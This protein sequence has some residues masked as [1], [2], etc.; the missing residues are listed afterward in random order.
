M[1][2]R[3]STLRP[4][5]VQR[6]NKAI[7]RQL[8]TFSKSIWGTLA[9]RSTLILTLRSQNP[10]SKI[11]ITKRYLQSS[12]IKKSGQTT[13]RKLLLTSSLSSPETA[14]FSNP[15]S[16]K[17]LS[18]SVPK[19]KDAVL[20]ISTSQQSD[21]QPSTLWSIMDSLPKKRR[22]KRKDPW[23]RSKSWKWAY[24]KKTSNKTRVSTVILK[25]WSQTF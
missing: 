4:L 17:A 13:S 25:Q 22:A 16:K 14:H 6:Q 7:S 2:T 5:R 11:L 24:L 19:C 20:M 18:A 3:P 9:K 1:C 10:T 21:N 23:Q 15:T 8:W 12:E